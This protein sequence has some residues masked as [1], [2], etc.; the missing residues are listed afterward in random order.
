MDEPVGPTV[1]HRDDAGVD[2]GLGQVVAVSDDGH[3]DSARGQ[4]HRVAHA[5]G[6]PHGLPGGG[7]EGP[8]LDVPLDL[9][10]ERCV[11]ATFLVPNE[12][13]LATLSGLPTDDFAQVVTAARAL[14]AKGIRTV[15]VTMG[16]K[17]SMLVT[18]DRDEYIPCFDRVKAI[19]TTGA[20]DSFIG[21]FAHFYVATGDLA[22]S[23]RKATLYAAD[24]V[25]KPGT[26]KSYASAQQFAEFCQAH[27]Q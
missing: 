18:A 19:D 24:A 25:T 5:R 4:V 14:I 27:G 8:A 13:E 16:K 1:R 22:A 15:I 26:Q 20:G 21:S 7:H 12:T 3:R 17:G 11:K 23:L 9:D 6:H 10:L 2:D